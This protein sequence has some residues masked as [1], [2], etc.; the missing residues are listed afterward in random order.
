MTVAAAIERSTRKYAEEIFH[1]VRNVMKQLRDSV[2]KQTSGHD[3]P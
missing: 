3:E 2:H 1:E